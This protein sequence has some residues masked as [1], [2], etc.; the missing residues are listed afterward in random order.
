MPRGSK[1]D[2]EGKLKWGKK[3]ANHGRKPARG[4]KRRMRTLKEVKK[5][6]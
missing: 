6:R 4:K 2:K 3:K 1:G 5:Q